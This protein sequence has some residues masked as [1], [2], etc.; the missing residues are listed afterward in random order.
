MKLTQIMIIF[1]FSL[2]N[3]SLITIRNRISLL[4][5]VHRL[6]EQATSE[7]KT[8]IITFATALI[9]LAGGGR[10]ESRIYSVTKFRIGN[11]TV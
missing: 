7:N 6:H 8:D 1:Q 2:K 10:G 5:P 3:D 9:L 11:A 4:R